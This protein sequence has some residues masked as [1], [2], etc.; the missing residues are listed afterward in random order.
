MGATGCDKKSRE[1]R[2]SDWKCLAAALERPFCWLFLMANVVACAAACSRS[3]LAWSVLC[4]A[5]G[6][7]VAEASTSLFHY[8]GDRRVF[9][10]WPLFRYYDRAYARHHRM[11]DDIVASG[12][13]GYA[14]WVGDVALL[15]LCAPVWIALLC[16]PG[17]LPL[18]AFVLL[19]VCSFIAV[20]A[21]THRLAHCSPD[22]TPGWVDLL[23]HGGLL[24][25]AESHDRHHRLANTT[26]RLAYFSVMTGWSNRVQDLL[27]LGQRVEC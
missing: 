21:D 5:L 8:W 15:P 25:S 1:P 11:P 14:Q 10:R 22:V 3:S 2:S 13:M 24:L 19:W 23:R 27:G 20:A 12:P 26:G 18:P 4:A 7:G 6:L 16:L 17:P 9:A